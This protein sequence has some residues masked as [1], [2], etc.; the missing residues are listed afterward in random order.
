MNDPLVAKDVLIFSIAQPCERKSCGRYCP[1]CWI[2][3]IPITHS[4]Q[5]GPNR[6]L[7]LHLEMGHFCV[8]GETHVFQKMTW[9]SFRTTQNFFYKQRIVPLNH[10]HVWC[11]A[12]RGEPASCEKDCGL[13]PCIRAWKFNG[14]ISVK[15]SFFRASPLNKPFNR[16][17]YDLRPFLEQNFV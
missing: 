2:T 14:A 12:G 7:F 17:F 3:H 9:N 15:S 6:R 8:P 13:Y 1:A 5:G 4:R 11:R 10:A 16:S